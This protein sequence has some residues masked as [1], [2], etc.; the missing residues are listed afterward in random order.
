MKDDSLRD[1]AMEKLVWRGL[2]ANLKPGSSSCPDAEILAAYIDRTLSTRERA[3]C[4]GHLASCAHCQ[5]H[6]AA[7]VRLSEVDAPFQVRA[8]AAPARAVRISWFRLA[9]AGPVLAAALVAGVYFM[10]PFRPIIQQTPENNHPARPPITPSSPPPQKY[11]QVEDKPSSATERRAGQPGDNKTLD[12]RTQTVA[13]AEKKAA[14]QPQ[15]TASRRE[16]ETTAP[17]QT[18]ANQN[19]SIMSEAWQTTANQNISI[20]SE[21][22]PPPPQPK[23]PASGA[24]AI[25]GNV[26][27]PQPAT[28]V[29]GLALRPREIATPSVR[30][31]IAQTRRVD[32]GAEGGNPSAGIGGGVGSGNPS[33][34]LSRKNFKDE[35]KAGPPQKQTEATARGAK[36]EGDLEK[37]KTQNEAKADSTTTT[38]TVKESRDQEPSVHAVNQSVEVTAA[39]P[40]VQLESSEVSTPVWRV[41]RRGLIEQRHLNGKWKK[42]KSGVKIDL[43]DIS[44][45]TP[46]V[47]W[48]VGQAGTILR[49]TDGGKTWVQLPSPTSEDIVH[50]TAIGDSAASIVTRSGK[51]LTTSDGGETW[52][53]ESQ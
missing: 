14:T 46:D 39:A 15:T 10:G 24:L 53:R 41:G 42:H 9:Y 11:G 12:D 37:A 20:V 23:P 43:N 27:T 45:A 25:T 33:N 44:F 36:Q 4:E 17:P 8:A 47:G 29:G 38:T 49:S 5:E 26:P 28:S 16:G 51:T 50:V 31:K 1:K 35:Q 18:T 48:A 21:A 22:P 52:T 13:R 40:P 19:P 30:A 32:G 2:R 3:D 6:V 7:L 34:N